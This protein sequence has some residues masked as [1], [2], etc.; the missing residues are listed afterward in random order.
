MS[1]SRNLAASLGVQVSFVGGKPH[2]EVPRWVAACD[3]FVLPSWNE[4]TPNVVIEALACGRRVVATRVGGTPDVV[5]SDTLGTLVPPRDPSA[6]AVALE[7]SL[8][9]NYDPAVVSSTLSAPDWGQSAQSLCA[10]LAA[11]CGPS[12][13]L[14]R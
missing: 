9:R 6:L 10:S 12:G 2:D 1:E 8:S 5:T 11:A 7:D 4:G 3:A 14:V 13:G